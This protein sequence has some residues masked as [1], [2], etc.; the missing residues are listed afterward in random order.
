VRITDNGKVVAGNVWRA[1]RVL[2]LRSILPELLKQSVVVTGHRSPRTARHLL[3]RST[4]TRRCTDDALISVAMIRDQ[5]I[6]YN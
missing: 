3:F 2:N 4:M 1:T 5:L 6:K